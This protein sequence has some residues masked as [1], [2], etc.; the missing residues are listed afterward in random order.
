MTK[1][2][3]VVCPETDGQ[4]VVVRR[5]HR[6]RGAQ[7]NT[8]RDAAKSVHDFGVV[9]ARGERVGDDSIRFVRLRFAGGDRHFSP[10]SPSRAQ[11]GAAPPK[12][13]AASRIVKSAVRGVTDT[14]P[15]STA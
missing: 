10:H 9:N 12:R 14:N 1:G 11:N 2:C 5:P 3:E 7:K 4:R 13:A 8:A 15:R 6:Q